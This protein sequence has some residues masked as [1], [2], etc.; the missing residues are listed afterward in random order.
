M[1]GVAAR[2][3]GSL[4][5]LVTMSIALADTPAPGPASIAFAN[6]GGVYN[7][8]ADGTKGLWVQD[9]GK[10]WYY[11][12]LMGPCTGLDFAQTLGFVTEADGSLDRHSSVTFKDGS[13]M[14]QRCPFKTFERSAP[15]P[16]RA[17]HPQPVKKA[18]AAS[19]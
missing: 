19:K 11:A 13:T 3:L 1:T 18:P 12:T 15:P 7:W 9:Q 10:N 6:H 2:T 4:A 17:K 5:L 8:K 16:T 14:L